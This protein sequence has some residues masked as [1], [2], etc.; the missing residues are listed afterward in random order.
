[1]AEIPP[2]VFDG[3][4]PSVAALTPFD[5]VRRRAWNWMQPGSGS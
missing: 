4:E 3:D 2:S 5:E 1:M